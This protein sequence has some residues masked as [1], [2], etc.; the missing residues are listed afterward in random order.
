VLW[1]V[2]PASEHLCVVKTS[3]T[4]HIARETVCVAE[5]GNKARGMQY[6]SDSAHYMRQSGLH[7]TTCLPVCFYL[8][9]PAA[10]TAVCQNYMHT[11]I[12]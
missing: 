11:N 7:W 4:D 12:Q 8:L 1:E 3:L 10:S 6:H 9:T 5:R 2:Q